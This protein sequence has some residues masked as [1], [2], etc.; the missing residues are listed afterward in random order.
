MQ[1]LIKVI[2]D[3]SLN[4]YKT[5]KRFKEINYIHIHF[6]SAE[7]KLLKRKKIEIL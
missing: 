7:T 1:E 4:S 6:V 3:F 5:H 2:I